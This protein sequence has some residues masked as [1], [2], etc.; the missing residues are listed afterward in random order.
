MNHE[1]LYTRD[2]AAEVVSR[3]L[4]M[5]QRLKFSVTAAG[6]WLSRELWARPDGLYWRSDVSDAI[7]RT[8][9]QRKYATTI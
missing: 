7:N 4:S 6:D 5:G 9:R 8:I 1:G 3:E 2:E